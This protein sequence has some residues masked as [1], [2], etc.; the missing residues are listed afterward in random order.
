[1]LCIIVYFTLEVYTAMESYTLLKGIHSLFVP[2]S[3]YLLAF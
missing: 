2:I 1:M 3:N